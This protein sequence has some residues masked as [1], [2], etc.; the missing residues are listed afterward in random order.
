MAGPEL[1]FVLA[2]GQN[3]FFVEVAEAFVGE[4]RA[5]GVPAAVSRDGFPPLADGTV[6]VLVPPHEYRGLAPPSH[7]PTPRQLE[8][9]I[10]YCFE[11]PGTRFFDSDVE[12]ARG[13]VGAVADLNA[14]SVREHRRRGVLAH[15]VP[16][17]WTDAWVAPQPDRPGEAAARDID[18]LHLGIYS[19]R[20]GRAL[21]HAADGLAR[22]RAA[23]I[24]GDDH[25]P[26]ASAQANFAVDGE[27]WRLLARSRVLLNVHL[28]ERPYFEWLRVVQAICNRVAVVSETSTGAAP[29]R[30]GEHFVSGRADELV[31][32]AEPLLED[33]ALRSAMA[34]RAASFLSQRQP[35]RASAEL[36]AQLAADIARRPSRPTVRQSALMLS[37]TPGRDV[38]RAAAIAMAVALTGSSPPA[39]RVDRVGLDPGFESA[40]VPWPDNGRSAPPDP[41]E[42]RAGAP[43]HPA[44]STTWSAAGPLILHD[45]AETE[46]LESGRALLEE[47]LAADLGAGFAWGIV[48]VESA[49]DGPALRNV[50][51]W[52]PWRLERDPGYIRPPVLWR[53][54]ALADIG[55]D[56]ENP[57]LYRVA[58]AKGCRGIHLPAVVAIERRPRS[59]A[60]RRRS[61]DRPNDVG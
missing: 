37:A 45:G 49:G 35:L 3:H 22:W 59:T 44:G 16:I 60:G 13:P 28:G 52:Q 2:P 15:H 40:R 8:R 39:E 36:L 23:L 42:R 48:A 14:V 17:G 61:S 57:D 9:T 20:R 54:A 32:L 19:A 18:L 21:A 31:A 56:L 12:M 26:N 55:G 33:E 53:A 7:W 43:T 1:T 4:L 50:F 6:Y 46:L 5:L 51:P 34:D 29:L 41:A 30:A 27:K 47:A 25:G 11:Q 10:F 58:A 24:F 38:P